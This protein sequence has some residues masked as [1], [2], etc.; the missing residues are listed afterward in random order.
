MPPNGVPLTGYEVQGDYW[1]QKVHTWQAQCFE[2]DTGTVA[3]FG[4]WGDNL[5]GDASLKTGSPIRVELVLMNRNDFTPMTTLQGYNV[6]KLEPSQ[7][8]N[9]YKQCVKQESVMT[10]K[11][12]P[13][14][15]AWA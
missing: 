8:I 5:T 13:P 1:V 6:I 7:E 11:P 2:A 14:L 9:H 10:L 3:V 15:G 12:G 4:A